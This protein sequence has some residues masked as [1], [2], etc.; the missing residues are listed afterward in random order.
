MTPQPLTIIIPIGGME[1]TT[2]LRDDKLPQWVNYVIIATVFALS[3]LLS[4][5]A[6]GGL[7][8]D[9]LTNVSIIIDVCVAVYAALKNTLDQLG[10]TI[11]SPFAALAASLAKNAQ[12]RA[13]LDAWYQTMRPAGVPP[14]ASAVQSP[15][16]PPPGG[17]VFA[18]PATPAD[19][20][21]RFDLPVIPPKDP[22]QQPPT[23]Q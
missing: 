4:I 6:S 21:T 20:P 10:I 18:P 19:Q 23:N 1:L 2:L 11:P 17:S 15:P 9:P 5:V 8:G 16:V 12:M 14:R 22:Q 13:E 3:I 7:T